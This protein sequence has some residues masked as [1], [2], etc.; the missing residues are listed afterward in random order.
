MN[1]TTQTDLGTPASTAEE[2]V[3]IEIDGL[4]CQGESRQHHHACG[5]GMRCGR[6]QTLRHGQH[7]A[8]WLMSSLRC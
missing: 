5:A 3:S 6:P 1:P 4:A 8:V 2:T 7:E